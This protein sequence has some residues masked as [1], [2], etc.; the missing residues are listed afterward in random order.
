MSNSHYQKL[1]LRRKKKTILCVGELREE[2]AGET[3][4][5]LKCSF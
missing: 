1:F 2:S 3:G 4:T 5:A